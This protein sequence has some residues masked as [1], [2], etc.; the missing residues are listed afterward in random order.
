MF[1]SQYP[2]LPIGRAKNG[3]AVNYFGAGKINPEGI[4]ALTTVEQLEG[5][6][7]WSFMH[8]MKSE[9]RKTQAEDPDFVRC[10]GINIIDLQGLS[11]AALS[12]DTMAVIK[13]ASKI[14]DFFPEVSFSVSAQIMS[15]ITCL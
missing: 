6:F 10:E 14:S 7:W 5:Y 11:R 3:C 15:I 13:L 12:S 2:F 1:L 4:L 9:I 8:K